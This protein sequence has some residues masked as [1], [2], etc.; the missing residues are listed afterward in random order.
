MRGVAEK[1]WS[2]AEVWRFRPRVVA[3]GS[4]LGCVCDEDRLVWKMWHCNLYMV[5]YGATS[6]R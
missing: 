6:C 5:D 3:R 2:V 4:L 1:R